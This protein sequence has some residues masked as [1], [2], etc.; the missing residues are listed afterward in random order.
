MSVVSQLTS[1]PAGRNSN[2]RPAGGDTFSPAFESSARG[3]GRGLW[4]SPP[5]GGVAFP[6]MCT[7][8]WCPLWETTP[9]F[10]QIELS[11]MV[12][13]RGNPSKISANC[14]SDIRLNCRLQLDLWTR[15]SGPKPKNQKIIH[16]IIFLGPQASRAQTLPLSCSPWGTCTYTI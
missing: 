8:K 6:Y 1:P 4:R 13:L 9:K 12:S 16:M 15:A 10:P 3:G 11:R 2:V 14:A 7:L 5:A